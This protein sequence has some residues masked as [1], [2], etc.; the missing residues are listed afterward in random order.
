MSDARDLALAVRALVRD[1]APVGEAVPVYDAGLWRRLGGMG[2]LG[3]AGPNLGG[4]AAD[5]GQCLF[6]LGAGGVVGP[7]VETAMAGQLDLGSDR[8]AVEDGTAVA[9]V[10]WL[11]DLVPWGVLADVVIAVRDGRAYRATVTDA[12]EVSTLAG[13]EWLAGSLELGQDIGDAGPAATIGELAVAAYVTG[14]ASKIIELCA[15]YAR[16]RRQF[17]RAIGAYQAVAQPLAEMYARLAGIRDVLVSP[18]FEGLDF[19]GAD[20]AGRAARLRVIAGEWSVRAAQVGFQSQGGMGFVDGTELAHLGKRIRQ[21]S[22]A[23]VPQ[24]ISEE[25]AAKVG[26]R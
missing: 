7:V 25:R 10:T 1:R 8:A 26:A 3:L 4:T 11:D 16:T 13:D 20:A 14:A 6:E 22:L 9:T 18:S 15:E 24:P 21:V 5:V 2:V 17:G 23:G 12:R 19:G